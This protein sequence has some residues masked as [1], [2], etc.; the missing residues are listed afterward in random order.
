MS[1]HTAGD[2]VKLS[3]SNKPTLLPEQRSSIY[4]TSTFRNGEAPSGFPLT[5]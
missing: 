4:L 1:C 3:S 5:Y 2:I